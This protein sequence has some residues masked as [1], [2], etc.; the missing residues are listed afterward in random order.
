MTLF[1]FITLSLILFLG[2]KGIFSGFI[3]E[4][5]ALFGIIGGVFIASRIS[6]DFSSSS[7]LV[8]IG[9][10]AAFWV[11]CHFAAIAVAKAASLTGLG[12]LDKILGFAFGAGKVFFIISVIMFSISNIDV[13]RT[14]LEPKLK[15]SKM[16]NIYVY[17]GKAIM[18]V[19]A[20][21]IL[22][23]VDA[24]ASKA[25]DVTKSVIDVNQKMKEISK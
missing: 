11:L 24:N 13:I 21:S 17:S 20:N 6:T 7:L 2:L 12:V 18:K 1:D 9:V 22:N 4:A 23:K 14:K 10:F 19:D 3:K 15:D 25:V 16:Y 5:F 8:F